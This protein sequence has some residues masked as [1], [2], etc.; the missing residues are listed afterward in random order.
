MPKDFERTCTALPVEPFYRD[1]I[2]NAFVHVHQSLS[3]LNKK[4]QKRNGKVVAITPRHYLDFVTQF[5]K[6]Y[7]EKRADLEEQQSHLNNGLN[8]IKE[9]VDQVEDL[10]KSLSSKRAILE[11]KNEEAN[12]KL[13][14]MIVDQQEAEKTKLDSQELQKILIVQTEEIAVKKESVMTDLAR[15]EPAV[16]EAQQGNLKTLLLFLYSI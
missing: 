8:K 7:H 4:I 11:K 12:L 13:K 14:Q 16:Q 3:N 5:I 6:L 1:L 10:Q 9:T 2:H 15:V